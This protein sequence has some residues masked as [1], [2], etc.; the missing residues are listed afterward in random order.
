[1][2]TP[3]G[4][5][6]TF[7][8]RR[9]EGQR[10]AKGIG[11]NNGLTLV[12]DYGDVHRHARLQETE[13]F[14]HVSAFVHPPNAIPDI[15]GENSI[16]LKLP[17][18]KAS[19]VS[20]DAEM[21]RSTD[22]FDGLD[23]EKRGCVLEKDKE[24]ELDIFTSYSE[25]NCKIQHKLKMAEEYAG[26]C[27][28]NLVRY[29]MDLPACD[30]LS[31]IKYVY[32]LTSPGGSDK[33]LCKGSCETTR[34]S[35]RISSTE[36]LDRKEFNLWFRTVPVKDVRLRYNS[37]DDFALL[38]DY[39]R[40]RTA[41]ETPVA[42]A[43]GAAI[44]ASNEFESRFAVVHFYFDDL[45]AREIIKDAKVTWIG[46]LASAGGTLGLFTGFSIVSVLELGYFAIR[47]LP[48]IRK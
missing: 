21:Q 40:N 48:R 23:P 30:V 9:D 5:C 16:E 45:Y 2:E 43:F 38:Y 29:S 27:S 28:S 44:S 4:R 34:Y 18:G 24:A 17:V 36:K 32:N 10:L 13:N 19:F 11:Q 46:R 22:D 35:A 26:G 1:M 14:K 15:S 20:L 3:L 41:S 39:I 42:D 33:S 8:N 37:F 25:V 6:Y 7:N 31:S 12:M 47:L